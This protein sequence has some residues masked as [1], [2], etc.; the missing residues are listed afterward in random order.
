MSAHAPG[1]TRESR[2]TPIA[3]SVQQTQ[4]QLN[5]AT[6]ANDAS[7]RQHPWPS[8]ATQARYHTLSTPNKRWSTTAVLRA[9]HTYFVPRGVVAQLDAFRGVKVVLQRNPTRLGMKVVH[10]ACGHVVKR[11]QRSRV[12]EW[13]SQ[14]SESGHRELRARCLVASFP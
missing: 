4:R 7:A 3:H 9:R 13:Y 12:H 14:Q 11:I 10:P 8:T 6:S 5:A 2:T 1:W